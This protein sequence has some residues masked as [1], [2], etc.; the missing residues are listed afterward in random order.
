MA[1]MKPTLLATALLLFAAPLAVAA[2]PGTPGGVP[3]NNPDSKA[4]IDKSTRHGEWVEI[5]VPGTQTKLKSFVVHP[6][7]KDKT[8]F[9]IV[10]HDI[11]GM[12]DWPRAVADQLAADGFIAIVPDLLSGKGANGGGTEAV[13][14]VGQ[15]IMGLKLDEVAADLNAV[16]DYGKKLVNSN[17]KTAVV[18]FCW[19]GGQSFGYATVQPDLDAAVVYYGTP[20]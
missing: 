5:A 12:S 9:V 10:I 7:S 20:P 19:G 3:P 15:T 1:A 17:G 18:G 4:T 11:Y 13:G 8:P 16:R 14:N 6:E 2:D